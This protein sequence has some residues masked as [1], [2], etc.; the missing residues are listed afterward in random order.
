MS[1]DR[2]PALNRAGAPASASRLTRAAADQPSVIERAVQRVRA[3]GYGTSV[4]AWRLGGRFPQRLQAPPPNLWTGDVARGEAL[5][6]GRFVFGR[7]SLAVDQLDWTRLPVSEAMQAWLHSFDWLHDL[8]AATTA[9]GVDLRTAQAVAEP[10]TKG[11]IRPFA[12]YDPLA[13]R[14]DVMGERLL[15]WCLNP[16]QIVAVNDHIHRSALLNSLARSA[17]H[18]ARTARRTPTGMPRIR[19]TGGLAIASALL[20]GIDPGLA[21]GVDG[22]TRALDRM[23]L[24]DGGIDSRSPAVAVPLLRWLLAVRAVL[25]ATNEAVPD[26]LVRA[27]DRLVPALRGLV[28]GDGSLASFHGGPRQDPAEVEALLAAAGVSSKPLRNGAF[29]GFQ[30]L[31]YGSTTVIADCGPPP[32][33]DL[34]RDAHAGTLAFE[35][36]DISGRIIL[37]CGSSQARGSKLPAALIDS[38]RAS[39]A[40]STLVIADTNSTQI[41]ADG[42][43]GRGVSEV[44][45]T[46]Q[47]NEDGCWLS[48]AHDG[49]AA[50][51]GMTHER[52]LFLRS[53]GLDFRGED[54]L[55][56]VRKRSLIRRSPKPVS[57]DIR[58]HLDPAVDVVPTQGGHGALLRLPGGVTWSFKARGAQLTVSDSIMI[59]AADTVCQT[60]QL[61][62]SGKAAPGGAAINWSFKRSPTKPLPPRG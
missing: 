62:L 1:G 41:R 23:V 3:L 20:I 32:S 50:R 14:P 57:F 30:R 44:S 31:E 49:Y 51:Y 48:A 54:V 2:R 52:R 11:W 60:R 61:V 5:L 43:L 21:R 56:P 12:R 18:L 45:A 36:S 16:V 9:R 34:S 10:L 26:G 27:I 40:H 35:L 37:N 4:Y 28:H 8:A 55:V 13:W 46:R 59:D 53:D 15:A 6:D 19:A 29:S 58:F 17:R 33:G 24:P 22:L 38:L 47:E 7:E 42:R 39:A 25:Q